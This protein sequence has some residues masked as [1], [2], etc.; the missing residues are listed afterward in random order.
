MNF[1]Y[2]FTVTRVHDGDTIEGVLDLGLGIY[3]GRDPSPLF[4][5][6][7]AGINAPELSTEAGQRALAFLQTLVVPGDVVG[8]ESISWDK[9]RARIDGIVWMQDGTNLCQAMLDSGN[10]VPYPPVKA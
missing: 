7:F 1:Q 9:Y 4:G 8:V 2:Q 3:L 10:A 6:R 5:I